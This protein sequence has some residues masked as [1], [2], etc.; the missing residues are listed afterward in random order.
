[1]SSPIR[2][3]YTDHLL[4]SWIILN[5]RSR[6]I[7]FFFSFSLTGSLSLSIDTYFFYSFHLLCSHLSHRFWSL[8][9]VSTALFSSSSSDAIP[10]WSSLPQNPS[11]TALYLT[12]ERGDRENKEE[13]EFS[14]GVLFIFSLIFFWS[15]HILLK[16]DRSVVCGVEIC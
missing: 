10:F 15:F 11:F 2:S 7:F 6:F 16:F 1:M 13:I 4:N 3:I 9:F 8:N 14:R 12:G 5:Q